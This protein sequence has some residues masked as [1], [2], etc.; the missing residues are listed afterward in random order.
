LRELETI[1]RLGRNRAEVILKRKREPIY[2]VLKFFILRVGDTD[3]ISSP[4]WEH[5]P[6][7]DASSDDYTRA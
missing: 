7:S 3:K 2:D 6:A 5:I 4:P 1:M